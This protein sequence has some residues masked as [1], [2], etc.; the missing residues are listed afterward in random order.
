ML[1][2]QN[3][4]RKNKIPT[5]STKTGNISIEL[6]AKKLTELKNKGMASKI[7][8]DDLVKLDEFVKV[9]KFV[10]ASMTPNIWVKKIGTGSQTA[11]TSDI[12]KATRMTTVEKVLKLLSD[13]QGKS[14]ARKFFKGDRNQLTKINRG[15]LL[16]KPAVGQIVSLENRKQEKKK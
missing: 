10:E 16:A 4:L 13:F 12:V 8:G 5:E 1:R 11:F 9:G 15:A 2:E 6:I 14:G 7:F 3:D